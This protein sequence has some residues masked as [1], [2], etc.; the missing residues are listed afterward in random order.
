MRNLNNSD[1]FKI[2]RII[3]KTGFKNKIK[4]LNLPK[5]DEGNILLSDME[6]YVVL[7]M[8]IIEGAPDAEDEVF[9][10]LGDIAG[11]SAKKMKEDE[12]E[13]LFEL[14]GHLKGQ[15]KLVTFL[16]QAFK[17]AG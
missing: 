10:F 2:I 14:I 9:R 3:R 16:E 12:F 17:S 15:E 4:D 8:E 5:D 11:V 13:I 6:Y 7:L 1:L